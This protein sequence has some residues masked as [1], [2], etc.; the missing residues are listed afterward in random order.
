VILDGEGEVL[1]A[2]DLT[3]SAAG[4]LQITLNTAGAP[5]GGYSLVVAT[6]DYATA[7]ARASFTVR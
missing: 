7:L 6:P 1:N 3:T 4:T 5:P 2:L